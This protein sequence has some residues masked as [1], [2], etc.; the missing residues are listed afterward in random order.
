LD[1]FVVSNKRLGCGQYG[2]VLLGCFK[3]KIDKILAVKQIPKIYS[4]QQFMK[5]L[6]IKKKILINVKSKHVVA[7][8]NIKRI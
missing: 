5:I 6:S 8:Y 3:D 1:N 7:I 4:N 2:L